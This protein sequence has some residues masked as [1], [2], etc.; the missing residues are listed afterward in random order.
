MEQSVT[1]YLLTQWPTVA[2]LAIWWYLIIKYFM[3]ELEKKDE[4][5]QKNMDDFR[6]AMIKN[7]EALIEFKNILS[8]FK[9]KQ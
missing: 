2:V 7:T 1:Q 3:G 5:N 9:I 8:Q 6:E 4:Q